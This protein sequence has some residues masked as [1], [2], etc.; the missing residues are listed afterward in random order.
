MKI[1]KWEDLPNFEG[2]YQV[3]DF[4]RIKSLPKMWITG[5]KGT[6]RVKGE[7]IMKLSIDSGGYCQ[8]ELSKYKQKNKFLVHRIVAQ[9]FIDNPE[10]KGCVNHKNSIRNDNR[11]EN[12]EWCTHSENTNHAISNGRI[13]K[14]LGED[15]P[16]SIL[17]ESDVI[18]IR[19]IS[20]KY[21]QQDLANMFGVGRRAIGH[22][23]S[24]KTW[25]H[26]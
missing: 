15:H 20:D 1:E 7:T 19:S 17:S 21:T 10:G 4:G 25:G 9:V 23:I 11:V 5:N 16:M 6:L 18:K 2:I 26:I 22:V 13:E 12:L 14:R 8:V 3:S 24:R